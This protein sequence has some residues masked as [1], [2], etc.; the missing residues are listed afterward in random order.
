MT[1]SQTIAFPER[2]LTVLPPWGQAIAYANKRLENRGE[3]VARQIGSWRGVVGLSQ[4]ARSKSA[5]TIDSE[6]LIMGDD[7]IDLARRQRFAKEI[8]DRTK[9]GKLWLAAELVDL[10]SPEQCAGEMWHVEGQW[11]IILGRV[12]ELRPVACMGGQGMWRPQWCARCT[13]VVAN[14]H[15]RVC[16]T[17]ATMLTVQNM[18]LPALAIVREI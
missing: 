2:C 7:R 14:S 4:S 6:L 3:G 10:R 5:E 8:D 15:G 13:K 1:T 12:W 17:C 16:K 18:D 11:G 9:A